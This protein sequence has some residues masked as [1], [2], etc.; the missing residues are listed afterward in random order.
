MSH[1]TPTHGTES[2]SEGHESIEDT[3]TADEQQ[4]G[5][6]RDVIV[7]LRVYKAVSVFSTLIAVVAIVAGFIALDSATNRAT[8][9][10]SAVNPLVALAGLGLI[11]GGAVVYAF[12]TRFRTDGMGPDGGE[13]DG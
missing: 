8:A 9:E 4:P 1:A 5:D 11:L 3:A 12:S 13:T 10:L 2:T 6:R 7:P